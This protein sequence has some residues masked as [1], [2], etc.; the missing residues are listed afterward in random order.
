MS[1]RKQYL[2]GQLIDRASVHGV[3]KKE[4]S[5]ERLGLDSES[6]FSNYSSRPGSIA[7]LVRRNLALGILSGGGEANGIP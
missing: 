4:E 7:N 5:M 1:S 6:G 2:L 3:N